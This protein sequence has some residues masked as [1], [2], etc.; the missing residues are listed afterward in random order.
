[1]ERFDTLLESLTPVQWRER[2]IH[3]LTVQ[4]LVAHLI[5]TDELLVAQL[6]TGR[7]RDA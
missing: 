7:R 3:D 2:V 5:A 4:D 6:G 1:V